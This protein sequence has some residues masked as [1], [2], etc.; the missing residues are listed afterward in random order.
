MSSDSSRTSTLERPKSR[1]P[2]EKAMK[3][4][5]ALL[6]FI[7][8]VLLAAAVV[9]MLAVGMRE[10]STDNI[11][12]FSGRIEAPESRIGTKM[13]AQVKSVAVREGD[14]VRKG[15][16]LISLDNQ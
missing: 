3:I 13:P 15:Q 16:L 1:K 5:R 9:I 4:R 7:G 2:A 11:L 14:H 12:Q 10:E 6:L 8:L